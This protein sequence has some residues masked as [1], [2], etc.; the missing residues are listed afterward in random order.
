MGRRGARRGRG[1]AKSAEPS[2]AT[3]AL[4]A[5]TAT[6]TRLSVFAP[7]SAS[8]VMSWSRTSHFIHTPHGN[9]AGVVKRARS[10]SSSLRTRAL[11]DISSSGRSGLFR[12]GPRVRCANHRTA[13]RTEPA[14]LAA[15]ASGLRVLRQT[16]SISSA[17]MPANSAKSIRACDIHPTRVRGPDRAT[18]SPSHA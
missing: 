9:G 15:L 13:F 14:G 17:L 18:C 1:R 12:L 16:W 3:S 4:M 2:G 6:I 8:L 7:N 11:A 5:A 10:A